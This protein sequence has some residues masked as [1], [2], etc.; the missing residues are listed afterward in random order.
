MT[1]KVQSP[2]NKIQLL[3]S[4]NDLHVEP[5]GELV[6]TGGKCD[7]YTQSLIGE[8]VR[9]NGSM[10]MHQWGD[11][12]KDEYVFLLLPEQALQA[13]LCDGGTELPE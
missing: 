12:E 4:S 9:F 8:T 11:F 10:V 3:N 1:V 5:V 2:N 6:T 13:V 7:L